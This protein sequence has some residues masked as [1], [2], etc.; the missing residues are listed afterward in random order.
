MVGAAA[1]KGLRKLEAGENQPPLLCA[2]F[3]P[4]GAWVAL[5]G[6]GCIPCHPAIWVAALPNLET[7]AALHG[8]QG[9]HDLAWDP[10]SGLLASASNDYTVVLWDVPR[11][12]HVL[13]C[14]G[15]DE[16]IVKGA[17]AFGDGVLYVGESEPFEDLASRLLRVDLTTGDTTVVLE[18]TTSD[19]SRL[20]IQRLAVDPGTDAWAFVYDI[21]A[22]HSPQLVQGRGATRA[23]TRKLAEDPCAFAW[24]QGTLRMGR[25]TE[26]DGA[27]GLAPDGTEVQV[28]PTEVRSARW[29]TPLSLQ[30]TNVVEVS[31]EGD[32]IL[33]AGVDGIALLDGHTGE[34]LTKV[35][36]PAW[37]AP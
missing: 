9:V 34:L 13:A 2:A 33:V 30:R 36:P 14:G 27:V 5:A 17:V 4:D 31:P 18:L 12:D 29:R 7:V 16:P 10:G 8:H 25:P 15:D 11:E 24:V 35:T 37:F 28:T 23:S 26:V 6:G 32:R 1:S 3:S 22:F 20:G 21:D 19:G